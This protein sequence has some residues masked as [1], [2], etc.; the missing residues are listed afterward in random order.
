M[1]IKSKP[2]L[3]ETSQLCPNLCNP[4]PQIKQNKSQIKVNS[5]KPYL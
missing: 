3:A 2:E 5:T 4:E 1:N